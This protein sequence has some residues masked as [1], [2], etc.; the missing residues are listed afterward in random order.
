MNKKN[1]RRQKSILILIGLALFF[2]C[3]TSSPLFSQEQKKFKG[4]W[5]LPKGYPDGFDG[6]G[7]INRIA[8]ADAGIVIDEM[9]FRLSPFIT[10]HW[11]PGVTRSRSKFKEG[12]LIGFLKSP[13]GLITSLWLIR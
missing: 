5:V 8:I 7:H 1:V 11:P 10:F 12:A 2:T 4:E 13:G 3:S 9:L 6:W